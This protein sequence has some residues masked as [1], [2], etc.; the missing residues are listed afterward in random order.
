M[1]PACYASKEAP[2]FKMRVETDKGDFTIQF[3]NKR[4][5]LDLNDPIEGQVVEILDKLIETR[6][7]ISSQIY[8]VDR[9]A[10]LALAKAHQAAQ[11]KAAVSGTTSSMDNP[12]QNVNL[13]KR[14]EELRR[15]GVDEDEIQ[16]MLDKMRTNLQITAPSDEVVREKEGFIP[17]EPTEPVKEVVEEAPASPTDV[18]KNLGKRNT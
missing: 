8:K 2:S 17:N 13:E 9:E 14:G 18:F 7:D 6:S 1:A 11:P 12:A 16:K 3:V 10:A 5:E 4:L 15:Q